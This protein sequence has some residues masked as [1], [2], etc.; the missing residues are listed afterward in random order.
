MGRIR[1]YR[2]AWSR[3]HRSGGFGIHSP[4]AFHFVQ[5]VLGERLPYYAYADIAKWRMM[6]KDS[7]GHSWRKPRVISLKN[8]KMLFRIANFFNPEH[9]L[10]V[11]ACYGV[12]A[13]SV[14]AVSSQSE[15]HL[16][17]PMFA[18]S[19]IQQ[20]VLLPFSEKTHNYEDLNA[21]LES[22][23]S[24]LT[25]DKSPFVLINEICDEMEYNILKSAILPLIQQHSVVV[26][27]NL[28]KSLLLAQLWQELKD[29]AEYGQT[30][31]NEKIGIIIANP[32]LQLE[33]FFLW[34]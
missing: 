25:P 1:R 12:S 34:F 21:C 10:V 8:A 9:L 22:Y 4:F 7:A 29:H 2:T 20:K 24:A 11:G 32:K 17:S 30:Y 33:H 6:A 26:M 16:Y 19:D 15:L 27:R 23:H 18:D 14:K 5:R 3:H 28:T 31:T 13:A